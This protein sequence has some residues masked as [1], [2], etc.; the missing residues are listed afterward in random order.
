MFG[1]SLG[2]KQ[3][4]TPPF[5]TSVLPRSARPAFQALH[6][7]SFHSLST[8]FS[9][10]TLPPKPPSSKGDVIATETERRTKTRAAVGLDT[11][12]ETE[13]VK[14]T[15]SETETGVAV[16]TVGVPCPLRNPFRNDRARPGRATKAR[17]PCVTATSNWARSRCPNLGITLF[18][19]G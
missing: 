1:N 12:I 13:T 14:G 18:R 7:L 3:P 10:D 6:S 17:S 11:M 8:H 15:R 19:L 4:P 2:I 16:T 9:M 5:R